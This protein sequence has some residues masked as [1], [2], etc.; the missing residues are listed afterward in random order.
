MHALQVTLQFERS[1]GSQ[2]QSNPG[3]ATKPGRDGTRPCMHACIEP[4]LQQSA[5]TLLQRRTVAM[6]NV[7]PS[8][9]DP[10]KSCI[11]RV[12]DTLTSPVTL[13]LLFTTAMRGHRVPCNCLYILSQ[14]GSTKQ[15]APLSC[16]RQI[17]RLG[18]RLMCLLEIT[19]PGLRQTHM[20]PSDYRTARVEANTYGTF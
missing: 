19:P 18:R 16:S 17:L 4:P 20:E 5:L 11:A 9:Y 15:L 12:V 14:L 2:C 6:Q 13:V 8:S 3:E 1:F 7:V 10:K